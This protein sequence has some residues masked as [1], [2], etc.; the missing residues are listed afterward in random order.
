MGNF[1]VREVFLIDDDPIVRMVALKILKSIG[2]DQAI[3]SYENGQMAIDEIHERMANRKLDPADRPI[4][5]LLDINMPEL[6]AWGFLDA[7]SFL[8]TEIKGQF[9][10]AIITSSI[11]AKDRNKAF[12]Y[13]EIIDYIT[14]PLSAKYLLDFLEKH[15]LI[16]RS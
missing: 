12:S 10:I 5:A 11:D 16:S 15:G 13:P 4:L 1:Q 3:S 9:L 2:F 14:K 8:P 6:D 7:F